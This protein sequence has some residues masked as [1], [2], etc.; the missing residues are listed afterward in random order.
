MTGPAPSSATVMT[1][2]G[3]AP[4]GL[5]EAT[6]AARVLEVLEG[7]TV[8]RMRNGQPLSMSRDLLAV[9][10]DMPRA[11]A[12]RIADR[13]AAEGLIRRLKIG[14]RV[15]YTRHDCATVGHADRA[16]THRITYRYRGGADTDVEVVCEAC[17]E[18]Y[19]RR[20]VLA[21][22]TSVPLASFAGGGAS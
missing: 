12:A 4:A 7:Q 16:G 10:A 2:M 20:P 15:H 8:A 11:E 14:G 9:R 13:L 1:N 19:A 21:D 6:P 5:V 22:F 17:A 3:P 18:S